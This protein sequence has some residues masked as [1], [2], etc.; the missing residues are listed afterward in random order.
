MVIAYTLNEEI[1]D[2]LMILFRQQKEAREELHWID[3][4]VKTFEKSFVNTNNKSI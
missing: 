3:K 1:Y 4:A 2:R